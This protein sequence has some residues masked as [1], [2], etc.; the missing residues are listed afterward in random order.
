MI[1]FLFEDLGNLIKDLMRKI[2]KSDI[3]DDL[4]SLK[5]AMQIKLTDDNLNDPSKVDIG[6]CANCSSLSTK[7]SDRERYRFRMECRNFVKAMLVKLLD[8]APVKYKLVRNLTWLQPKIMFAAG[9]AKEMAL[10]E[11]EQTL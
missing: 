10:S 3:L 11:L 7:A 1:P 9:T 4:V 8:K 6:F 5:S 2:V